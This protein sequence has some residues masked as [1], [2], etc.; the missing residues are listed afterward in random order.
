MSDSALEVGMSVGAQCWIHL[1]GDIN[2][3][4][5]GELLNGTNKW[6]NTICL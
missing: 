4:V 6:I 2:R 3:L 1:L 5:E